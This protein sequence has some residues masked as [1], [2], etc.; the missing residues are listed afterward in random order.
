[1]DNYVCQMNRTDGKGNKVFFFVVMFHRGIE[2][3]L[4]QKKSKIQMDGKET[5]DH[6]GVEIK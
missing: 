2:I 6:S 4:A 5:E 3:G 1:M